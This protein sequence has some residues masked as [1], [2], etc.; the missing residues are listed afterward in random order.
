M[1]GFGFSAMWPAILAFGDQYIKMTNKI[2]TIFYLSSGVTNIATSFILG[3]YIETNP[4]IFIL[5][6]VFYFIA[7]LSLFIISLYYVKRSKI[8]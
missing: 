4:I 1:K 2:G 8:C 3:P 7:S 6:E 5:L